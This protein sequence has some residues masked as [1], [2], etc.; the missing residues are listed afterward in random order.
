MQKLVKYSGIITAV[1]VLLVPTMALAL[2]Q[3]TVPIGNPSQV[4]TG[5]SLANLINT[6][7][8]YMLTIGTVFAVGYIIWGAFQFFRGKPDEG[9]KILLN[10]V[11]GIAIIFGVGLL[12]NTIA[13]II[14]TQ[15]IG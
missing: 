15:S 2:V 4:V 6:V 3:P 8:Q 7:V 5:S 14:Q 1:A 11:I 13:R 10:G 9:K 12:L